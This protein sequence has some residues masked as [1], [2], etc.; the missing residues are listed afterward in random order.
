MKNKKILGILVLLTIFLSF[1]IVI[2][3]PSVLALPYKFAPQPTITDNT[4]DIIKINQ[5]NQAIIALAQTYDGIDV[6]KIMISGQNID[7]IFL[8]N[9]AENATIYMMIDCDND[10]VGN[11]SIAFA[12]H[13]LGSKAV[14]H[15][16]NYDTP[17]KY[18]WNTTNGWST[19][20]GDAADV[21]DNNTN[22]LNITIPSAAY[23][24]QP[25]DEFV[26]YI[27]DSTS[28]LEYTYLEYAP[29]YTLFDFPIPGFELFFVIFAL[30][31]IMGLYLWKKSKV[32]IHS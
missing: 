24:I 10:D 21:G 1:S 7:I 27:F 2:S 26:V 25:T 5:S 15:K 22:F 4:H 30:S 12:Y 16:G 23:T 8:G 6:A 3:I 9:V 19:A 20:L 31:A 28:S 13:T 14:L 29:D 32:Q 17:T 18:Y 11:F